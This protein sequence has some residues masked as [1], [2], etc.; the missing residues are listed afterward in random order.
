MVHKIL[1]F[2][3]FGTCSL[4][5]ADALSFSDLLHNILRVFVLPVF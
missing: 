4:V 1:F 2:A 5:C 3:G